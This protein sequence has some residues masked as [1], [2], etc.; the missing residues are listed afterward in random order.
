MNRSTILLLTGLALVAVVGGYV[1]AT[2]FFRDNSVRSLDAVA[3]FIIPESYYATGKLAKLADT[4]QGQGKALF[5]DVPET[6]N[7]ALKP[8]FTREEGFIGPDSC[9][10]C[11]AEFYDGFVQ[12]THYKTSTRSSR[13]R[14]LG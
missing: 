3:E 12:T 7:F 10:E 11:H 8:E 14:W 4:P 5:P 2:Y 1:A 9:K 6:G 13:E